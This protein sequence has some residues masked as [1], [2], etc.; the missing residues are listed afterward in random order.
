MKAGKEAME[1]SQANEKKAPEG[2]V[3]IYTENAASSASASSSSKAVRSSPKTIKATVM[4]HQ[5]VGLNWLVE[6]FRLGLNCILADGTIFLLQLCLV[7]LFSF[8]CCLEMGLGKACTA[9]FPSF[10]LPCF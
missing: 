1:A 2:T 6:R 8:F 3:D 7:L 4:P 5:T 9:P 10:R